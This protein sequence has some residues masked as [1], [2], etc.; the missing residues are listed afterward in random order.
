M[1]NPVWIIGIELIGVN[2][3]PDKLQIIDNIFH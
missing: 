2:Y 3:K 1:Q